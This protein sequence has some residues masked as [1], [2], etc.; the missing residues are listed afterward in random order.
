MLVAVVA[1]IALVL[2]GCASA[3]NRDTGEVTGSAD[4]AN[5]KATVE[6]LINGTYSVPPEAGP[7]AV[8]GKR[9]WVVSIN[10]AAEDA[11]R[12]VEGVLQAGDAL[13]W[14][15]TDRDG[16]NNLANQFS[17]C[18]GG[19][20]AARADG[21]ITQGIN[22]DSILKPLT[23]AK[24]A[25]IPVISAGGFDCDQQTPPAGPPLFTAVMADNAEAPTQPM[26][27][28]QVGGYLGD[29]LI[30]TTEGSAK[31][32]N[33]A[34]TGNLNG[35]TTSAALE[36]SM[37]TCSD[38]ALY[39]ANLTLEQINPQSITSL[40]QTSVLR[41]PDANAAVT[42]T[43]DIFALASQALK[44]A[45]RPLVSISTGGSAGFMDLIRSGTITAGLGIDYLWVGWG[46]ADTM[47]RVFAGVP[48]N[49]PQ[50]IGFQ[51]VDQTHALPPSGQ[52]FT[53]SAI[54]YQADY[55]KVWGAE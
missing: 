23:D 15:T 43:A 18:V 45:K 52:P 8:A 28:N 17:V 26:L 2:A 13:A 54:D 12:L 40:L 42:F 11:A 35:T 53:L 27:W 51:L 44:T 25:G 7:K 48:A 50:G 33:V 30:A 9:V 20:I 1:C 41:N 22:C 24:A 16:N 55:K 39:N 34:F 46:A 37:A 4:V 21:I 29:W 19:A 14:K 32:I 31:A 3:G 47:N 5:S 10:K 6:K 49:V 38:C 36:K